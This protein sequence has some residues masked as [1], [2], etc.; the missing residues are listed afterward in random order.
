MGV[1]K[2]GLFKIVK[3]VVS[4]LHTL[5]EKYVTIKNEIFNTPF[6]HYDLRNPLCL[7]DIARKKINHVGPE[8]D[9][10][11]M[12]NNSKLG[13]PN[14]E[15]RTHHPY[16]SLNSIVGLPFSPLVL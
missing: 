14:P 13:T 9:T 10:E 3:L 11:V 12:V 7:C 2:S 15:P 4:Q 5:N 1:R 16:N 8:E 6:N